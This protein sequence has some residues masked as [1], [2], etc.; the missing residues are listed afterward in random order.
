MR[1]VTQL[2]LK[3][4]TSVT[5]VL[6]KFVLPQNICVLGGGVVVVVGE[7]VLCQR[8]CNRILPIINLRD[9]VLSNTP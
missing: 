3:Q 8:V 9:A 6:C 1:L 4:K 2:P 7:E 5:Q